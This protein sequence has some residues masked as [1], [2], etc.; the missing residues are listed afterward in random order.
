[1]LNAHCAIVGRSGIARYAL[2]VAD[3][4]VILPL[5][6]SAA[7][8]KGSAFARL[9]GWAP[10]AQSVRSMLGTGG[11]S[12]PSRIVVATAQQLLSDVRA[13]LAAHDL[14]TVAVVVAQGTGTR[15]QCVK[16]GMDYLADVDSTQFVLIHDYRR[17]LASADV[18]DRVMARLRDG[19][20][21][22]VPALALVDSVKAVDSLGSVTA[23][24]D[25]SILRTVQYPRG[26][27]A[28]RLSQLVS[29]CTT[30]T[31]DELSE[32]IGAGLSITM[33][34][35]DPDAFIVVV[36]RD[37]QLVEAIISCRRDDRR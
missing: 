33:V 2:A 1:V 13:C 36:P 23:T 19:C 35:G 26:F 22:V 17:P 5:P 29:G 25:R 27:A 16:A 9:V 4:S 24:V 12:E 37:S 31:F 6:L 34:D 15:T 8:N 21:V 32:A 3:F 14:S 30:D 20:E 18:R 11:V 7:E 28:N 10:L